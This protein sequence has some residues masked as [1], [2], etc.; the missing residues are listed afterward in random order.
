MLAA[1]FPDIALRVIRPRTGWVAAPIL[2]ES[3]DDWVLA[4]V[5]PGAA[6]FV[7]ARDGGG[8]SD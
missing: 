3:P 5:P 1:N 6:S 4:R 8:Q 2:K 7:P